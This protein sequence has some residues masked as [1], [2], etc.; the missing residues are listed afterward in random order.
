MIKRGVKRKFGGVHQ[1]HYQEGVSIMNKGMKRA[2]E[3]L[4]LTIENKM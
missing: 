1:K 2:T 4:K 3:G